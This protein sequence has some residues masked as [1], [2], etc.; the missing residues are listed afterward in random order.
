MVCKGKGNSERAGLIYE[1]ESQKDD[2]DRI[3]P[4][5]SGYN[6][7]FL[8]VPDNSGCLSAYYEWKFSC[9][10]SNACSFHVSGESMVRIS[11]SG[12]RTSGM[13]FYVQSESCKTRVEKLYKICDMADL[14]RGDHSY[15][16]FG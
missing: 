1:T 7:V 2:P 14:D 12:R 13:P 16:C 8:S 4:A 11:L 5:F 3:V 9:F 10:F 15:I 6:M